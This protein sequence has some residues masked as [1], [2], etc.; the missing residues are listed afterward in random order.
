MALN[1]TIFPMLL[2]LCCVYDEIIG[3]LVGRNPSGLWQP[4]FENGDIAVVGD[5]ESSPNPTVNP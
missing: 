1:Q 5:S 4:V 2:Y 3:F